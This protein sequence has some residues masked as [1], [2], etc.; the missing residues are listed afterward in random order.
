MSENNNHNLSI[1]EIIKKAQKIR[2]EAAR[3]LQE[4]E[5]RVDEQAKAQ[6]QEVVVNEEAVARRVAKAVENAEKDED[7][8]A[9]V[10]KKK[11][12]DDTKPVQ[13]D[14]KTRPIFPKPDEDTKTVPVD[15]KTRPIFPKPDED[16][17]TVPVDDKTRPIFPKNDEDMKVVPEDEGKTKVV[18][19]D[20]GKDDKTRQVYISRD[21]GKDA[22]SDLEKVP[23]LIARDRLYDGFTQPEEE[24]FEE[25]T[26]VQMTLQGFS[27]ELEEVPVIDEDEAERDL[28]KRREEKVDKFRLFGP[29]DTDAALSSDTARADDYS[30][31]AD[32]DLFLQR[33]L[34]KK[35]G[36]QKR[37]VAT[38][39]LFVLSLVLTL[40]RDSAALPNI[41]TGHTGYFVCALVLFAATVISNL[42][43]LLHGFKLHKGINFDTP[44]AVVT[45]L[46]AVHTVF[47]TV[48][49]SLWIDN[50]TLLT[51]VCTASLFM[52][53]LGKQRMLTRLCDNFDFLTDG[54]DKYTVENI[55]NAV[56]TGIISRGLL[57]GENPRLK[58]SVKTDFA[59]NFLEISCKREPADKIAGR[60]FGV[61]LLL[62]IAL[63]VTIGLLDNFNTGINTAMCALSIS[64]P[65]AVLFLTNTVLC[66]ISSQLAAFGSCVCGYE[67]AVMAEDGDAI[68][69]EAADLFDKSCCDLHG[70]K[71]FRG[72]KIDDALLYIASVIVQTK[73]PL[74]H[75]FEE[76]II[77][78]NILPKVEGVQY[79]ERLGTSAWVYK[80]KVLVGTRELLLHHGINVTDKYEK[81]YAIKER[82]AVYLAIGGEPIAMFVVS[83]NANPDLRRELTKLEK[84]GKI[85]IVK[86]SDPYINEESLARI[87]DLPEGFIRVM[88]YPAAKV[89]EKY[90]SP[91]VEKSPSYLAHSGTALSL[92]SAMRG[93]GIIVGTQ[94]LLAFLTTFGCLLGFAIIAVLAVLESYGQIGVLSILLFQLIWYTFTTVVT[95]L[96]C[97]GI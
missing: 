34:S 54:A 50:G 82:K 10:P 28:S 22:D 9:Y 16:T 52:S 67:G 61:T 85:L 56:D 79:E 48:N 25:E 65:A 74:R 30:N 20:S 64:M 43:V 40:A 73:S 15:D 96:K 2:E 42:N 39:I 89:Y 72:A 14:R 3:Q 77:G 62:S 1:D 78:Q 4:A 31:T 95:K 51:S 11:T 81:K 59:T 90:S 33:L 5:K 26:G 80:R 6:Q 23:T 60:I 68:V 36:V 13:T 29:E 71:T 69:M 75:V 94:G 27:D 76:V 38:G 53:Q 46:T 35:S 21:T 17:K 66:D 91:S 93:A 19:I 45:L 88:N 12:E 8:K 84:T 41:L 92:V 49:P 57:E 58:Y 24:G 44:V 32:K 87:F 83:Y 63:M 47:L 37:L 18:D 97:L 7:V 86:S 55:A 70:F